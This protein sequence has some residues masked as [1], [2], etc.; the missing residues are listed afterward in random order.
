MAQI[1]VTGNSGESLLN[2]FPNPCVGDTYLYTDDLDAAWLFIYDP[3][4]NIKEKWA[5]NPG[6]TLHV[7][8]SLPPGTYQLVL[9]DGYQNILGLPK[10]LFVSES[11]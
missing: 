1:G 8:I 9:K 6:I 5:I 11:H 2:I 3:D 4:G 7:N 10:P